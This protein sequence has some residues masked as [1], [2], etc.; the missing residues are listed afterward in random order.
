MSNRLY[1][2]ELVSV[3]M[4]NAGDNPGSEVVIY[5]SRDNTPTPEPVVSITRKAGSLPTEGKVSMDLSVIEDADL[6][7]SI[8]DE[9]VEKDARIAELEAAATPPDDPVEKADPEV[10]ELISKLREDLDKERSDRRT[11]EFVGKAEPFA[12]LLGKADEMGPVL[13]ALEAAAPE[14]Y[15]K[16]EHA[17]TAAS[18]RDELSKLF[19][20]VGT[21]EGEGES[22][23]ISKRDVWVEKNKTTSETVGQA[24]KRYWS[25][26]PEAKK[27][28]R[29]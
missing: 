27:E 20:E 23:P 2:D 22:D 6:R 16:L 24:R 29:A 12:M 15:E 8:E 9:I 28:S 14:A 19:S 5:K 7:K 11:S 4:V 10:Q 13:D 21:G 17:L 25:E 18:Q 1:V 3:G 26:N